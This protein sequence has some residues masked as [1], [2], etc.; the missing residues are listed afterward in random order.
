MISKE[1]LAGPATKDPAEKEKEE[2]NNWMGASLRSLQ[3]QIE[4]LDAELESFSRR[5]RITRQDQGIL[6]LTSSEGIRGSFLVRVVRKSV[7]F[8]CFKLLLKLQLGS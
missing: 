3:E 7:Y 6:T 2:C 5:R 1:G 4:Q 8:L